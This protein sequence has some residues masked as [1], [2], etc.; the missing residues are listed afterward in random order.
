[1][2]SIVYRN[3]WHIVASARHFF[4]DN[5]LYSTAFLPPVFVFYPPY[6]TVFTVKNSVLT[7]L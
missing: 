5:R 3:V 2:R 7:L 4:L 6:H 1:M